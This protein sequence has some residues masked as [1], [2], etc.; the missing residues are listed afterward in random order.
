[1]IKPTLLIFLDFDGVLHY[2]FPKAGIP[3]EDNKFFALIPNFE[4]VINRYKN[5][6][7]FKIV[8][9]SSWR[10]IK[11]IAELK[12][13]FSMEIQKLIV[14]ITP[15]HFGSGTGSRLKECEMWMQQ[16]EYTGNWIGIDDNL[17]IWNY[18]QN[19]VFCEDGLFSNEMNVF[20][21]W[22]ESIINKESL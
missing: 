2:F 7:D 8:I 22:C 6:V 20:S 4:T 16:N 18:H 19:V 1:M 14:G 9:S 13:P 15:I 3:D 12:S 10:E 11:T 5:Q 21:Q 17:D